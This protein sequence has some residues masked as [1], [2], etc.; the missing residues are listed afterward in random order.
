M[1]YEEFI[2]HL[3]KAGLSV[4]AFAGLVRMNQNSVSNYAQAGEVPAHLAI[5]AALMGEMGDHGLDFKGVLSRIDIE[6]KKPRGA[7]KRGGFQSGGRQRT[8]D[9]M[10]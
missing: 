9:L 10:S 7:S 8:P 3:G 5:M 1:T 2:R 6:P 4:R